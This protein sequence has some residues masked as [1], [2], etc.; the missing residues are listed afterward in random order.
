LTFRVSAVLDLYLRDDVDIE[1]YF[2]V[3]AGLD[4]NP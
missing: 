3:G 1:L 2:R 4:L